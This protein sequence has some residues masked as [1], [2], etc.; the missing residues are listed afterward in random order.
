MLRSLAQVRVGSERFDV[1][2]ERMESSGVSSR[3]GFAYCAKAEKVLSD[4]RCGVRLKHVDLSDCGLSDIPDAVF[5]LGDCLEILNLGGNMISKLSDSVIALQKLRI[6]FFA[7]NCFTEIPSVLGK[8][9]SLYMLSFKCNKISFIDEESLSEGLGWLILTDN[10][11]SALPSS[12]GKLTGLR[13]LMLA[14]NEIK[15]LTN[16]LQNCKVSNFSLRKPSK[17]CSRYEI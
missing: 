1:L 3:D 11:I 15:S 7:Q 8:L 17:R 5:Q 6:L 4:I 14:G 2:T 9:S 13:K 10:K 12:I 16:E